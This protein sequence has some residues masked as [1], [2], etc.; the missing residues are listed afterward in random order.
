MMLLLLLFLIWLREGIVSMHFWDSL[1]FSSSILI[2]VV[3]VYG[4]GSIVIFPLVRM[5]LLWWINFSLVVIITII[6]LVDTLAI[7][8]LSIRSCTNIGFWFDGCCS[9][10]FERRH[11]LPFWRFIDTLI[12][13][14]LYILEGFLLLLPLFVSSPSFLILYTLMMTTFLFAV[15]I[16][17][18]LPDLTHILLHTLSLFSLW[19]FLRR[20]FTI[21]DIGIFSSRTCIILILRVNWHVQLRTIIED[22]LFIWANNL[23]ILETARKRN[24]F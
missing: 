16:P 2:V 10:K 6:I 11:Q 12:L 19:T 22:A 7:L 21:K 18:F 8:V 23:V 15:F 9:W 14:A 13:R 17:F 24:F 5:L 20:V 3:F 4:A 1:I